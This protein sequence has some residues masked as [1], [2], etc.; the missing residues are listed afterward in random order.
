MRNLKKFF[1]FLKCPLVPVPWFLWYI[2]FGRRLGKWS[3]ASVE[4]F[5][6]SFA[7]CWGWLPSLGKYCQVPGPFRNRKDKLSMPGAGSFSNCHCLVVRV[8]RLSTFET[9]G[10]GPPVCR[11]CSLVG[12]H[13]GPGGLL[14][15]FRSWLCHQWAWDCDST[16]VVRILLRTDLMS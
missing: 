5:C 15:R 7:V 4:F 14:S 3:W 2:N 8:Y 1:S 9:P 16:Y 12:K 11:Q 6:F 13:L 10:T